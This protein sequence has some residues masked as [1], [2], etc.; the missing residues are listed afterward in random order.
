MLDVRDESVALVGHILDDERGGGLV[1]RTGFRVQ[2]MRSGVTSSRTIVSIDPSSSSTTL[3]LAVSRSPIFASTRVSP[4][5]TLPQ[6]VSSIVGLTV[7]ILGGFKAAFSAFE[8]ALG[9]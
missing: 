5:Y 9:E 3:R 6:V 2:D 4:V 8:R 7:G 1:Q